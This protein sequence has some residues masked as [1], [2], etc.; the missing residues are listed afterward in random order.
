LSQLSIT[1]NNLLWFIIYNVHSDFY[2]LSRVISEYTIY[3][4]RKAC[5]S[6]PPF[7]MLPWVRHSQCI[8]QFS[9]TITKYLQLGVLYRK[10][11]YWAHSA[12]GPRAS[13][14]QLG[15]DEALCWIAAWWEEY[16]R[17]RKPEGGEASV[18]L[19]SQSSYQ[20]GP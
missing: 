14:H 1:G 10:E 8:T 3:K 9:V 4:T 16:S 12:G 20:R 15:T 7:S 19:F 17:H 6:R 2:S 11:V 13:W 18:L 5:F